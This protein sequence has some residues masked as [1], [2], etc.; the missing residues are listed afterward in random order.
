MRP[1]HTFF[2]MFVASILGVLLVLL[3]AH[4]KPAG[5]I[6]PTVSTSGGLDGPMDVRGVQE[7]AG[8]P[9]F[10]TKEP[11]ASKVTPPPDGAS[12]LESHC[13]RCHTVQWIK[14]YEKPRTDWERILM[15]MAAKGAFLNEAEKVVLLDYLT[16]P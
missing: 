16:D 14:Q 12:L 3:V 4:L 13:I 5:T 7:N 11:I 1:R 6:P 10:E 9:D 2:T 15:Q 8:V